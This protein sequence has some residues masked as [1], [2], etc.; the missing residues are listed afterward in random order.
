M[1]KS[2][3][4]QILGVDTLRQHVPPRVWYETACLLIRNTIGSV[5]CSVEWGITS[6]FMTYFVNRLSHMVQEGTFVRE[7][8]A[9]HDI[10]L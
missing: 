7:I 3:K 8:L 9:K 10:L 6:Y 5:S 4:D 2:A 1:L